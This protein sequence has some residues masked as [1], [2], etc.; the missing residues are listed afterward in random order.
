MELSSN[1]LNLNNSKK[2]CH[3]LKLN[4]AA[5]IEAWNHLPMTAIKINKVKIYI[6]KSI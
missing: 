5:D 2:N 1:P 6:K 3:A 4:C